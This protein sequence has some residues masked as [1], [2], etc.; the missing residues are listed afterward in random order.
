MVLT[1]T[2][3]TGKAYRVG[4]GCPLMSSPH[5]TELEGIR[6]EDH[7]DILKSSKESNPKTKR[8]ELLP[9]VLQLTNGSQ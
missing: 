6:R 3:P 8:L 1:C 2:I 9:K 5:L 4:V 7:Q